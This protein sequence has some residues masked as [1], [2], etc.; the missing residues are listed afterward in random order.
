MRG[1]LFRQPAF[2]HARDCARE[3]ETCRQC[4]YISGMTALT[5]FQTLQRPKSPNTYLVT[6]PGMQ[7]AA[8]PDERS[9]VFAEAPQALYERLKAFIASQKQWTVSEEAAG[10]LQLELVV[11]TKLLKF[12]DDVSIRVCPVPAGSGSALAIYSR[13]RVGHHD[14]G[15]NRKRVQSLIETLQQNAPAAA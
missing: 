11:T 13:S 4:P 2:F 15:A 14:L 9:P 12:K 7:S 1:R 6:P 10:E 8:E 3:C 5:D